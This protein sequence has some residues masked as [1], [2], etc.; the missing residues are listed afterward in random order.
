MV[1][2]KKV[3]GKGAGRLQRAV[4]GRQGG[5]RPFSAWA[6]ALAEA[7]RGLFLVDRAEIDRVV[8]LRGQPGPE[9]RISPRRR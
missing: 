8:Q 2:S 9:P 5:F 7:S 1:R 4:S 6:D 3:R